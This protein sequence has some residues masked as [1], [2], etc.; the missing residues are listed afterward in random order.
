MEFRG[1][2]LAE[3]N[4]QKGVIIDPHWNLE[5]NKSGSDIAVSSVI[6]DPHWNLEKDTGALEDSGFT[7][8]IDPHWNLEA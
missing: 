3:R 5:R 6:I 1:V 4:L 2:I 7:V 8:I